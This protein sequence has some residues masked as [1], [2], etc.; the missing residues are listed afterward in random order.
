MVCF[1]GATD[2]LGSGS[3][4]I[5]NVSGVPVQPFAR[6]VMTMIA[7]PTL[8]AKNDGIAVT[9]VLLDNPMDAPPVISNTTPAGVPDSGIAVV[10]TPLQ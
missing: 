3:T 10:V 4:V 5:I 6:G 2:T 8:L 1:I 9:P 7:V